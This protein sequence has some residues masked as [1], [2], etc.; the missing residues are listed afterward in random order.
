VRATLPIARHGAWELAGL[1]LEEPSG[2]EA[3][4]GH[5]N[6]ENV[7][8]AT[9]ASGAVT[10]GTASF[11]DAAGRA[12]STVSPAAWRATGAASGAR[13]AGGGVRVAFTDSGLPGIVRP[14]QP[15]DTRPVPVLVDPATAAAAGRGGTLALTVDG[16]PVAARVAGVL[17]RFPTVPTGSAGFV[18]ADEQTLA[19]ALDAQLP[20]QGR[21]DELWISSR[22]LAGLRAALD[23]ASLSG[24]QAQYRQTIERGLRD[25][26]VARAVLGTLIAAAA[27][28]AALAIV[29]LL[30]ALLGP[31]RDGTMESDLVDQGASPG[32]VR[33]QL[34]L[35]A[36]IASALGVLAG[37]AIA[38]ILARLAVDTISAVAA[39]TSG[40]PP[41]VTVDP[42]TE[43]VLWSA[44]GL[45]A[46]ALAA[47]LGTAGRTLGAR[48]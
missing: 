28:S 26:P 6:G 47:W 32:A 44:A 27:L 36:L 35:E 11:L 31:G 12:S 41:L 9:Q 45:A 25:A 30:A 10:L 38:L 15:S 43:L 5:Q 46:L 24:V 16:E 23:T 22:D 40:A 34:R 18:V 37:A 20:G 17:R 7:A 4:N 8:A 14:G 29:G 1:E 19:G 2:L 3:T 42:A 13:T 39:L 33:A 21:A 48:S